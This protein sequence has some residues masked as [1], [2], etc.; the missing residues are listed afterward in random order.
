MNIKAA[1]AQI[2][3][4]VGN[5]HANL[6]HHLKV[7][8]SAR[9]QGAQLVVF[10]ELSLTGYSLKDLAWEVALD[11]STSNVFAEL[12]SVSKKISLAV[13]FV[14]AGSN[15]GI[16]NS[17]AFLEDGEIKHIHRKVYPPTYGMFEEGRYFSAGNS[18]RAFD[19]KYGRF[20]MVICEDLWHMALPYLLA[21]DGAEA[22]F[23]LTASPTRMSGTDGVLDNK[24]VNTEHHRA[25][26]RLLSIYLLFANRVG[27]E[28]GVNFWGGS[29]ITAPNG[30]ETVEAKLW[31]E[32]LVF[33]M[34]DSTELQ[35]A[36]R[37]SRHF[38]D[39]RTE[40]VLRE[41]SAL[42]HLKQ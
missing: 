10:P 20:G 12:K 29:S 13:G 8:A 25:Y 31:D 23:A 5:L 34:L 11:P 9:E 32:D 26:A 18:V 28:D 38:I 6:A 15:H 33:G 37:Q 19:S 1:V 2:D 39:E 36:R 30:Q 22:L 41:L 35:R 14:E 42:Q 17:A 24:I 21:S 7:I 4:K 40:I 16:Y 3:A 27:F